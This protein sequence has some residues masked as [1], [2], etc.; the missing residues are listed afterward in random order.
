MP[1]Y[2][3][4]W[5]NVDERLLR[6]I[7]VHLDLDPEDPPAELKA[8]FGARPKEEFVDRSWP[9]L[10]DSWLTSDTR[11]R[12]AVCASLRERGL[13]AAG[14]PDEMAFLRS[15]RNTI[16]LRRVV[17]PEFITLGEG[18]HQVKPVPSSDDNGRKSRLEGFGGRA[19]VGAS[20]SSRP[21]D[22]DDS[23]REERAEGDGDEGL[24]FAPDDEDVPNATDHLRSWV[25]EV[26]SRASGSDIEIDENG[27]VLI[28]HG[29]T[30]VLVGVSDDPLCIEIDAVLLTDVDYSESLYRRLNE[31]NEDILTTSLFHVEED[32]TVYMRNTLI[33]LGLTASHFLGNLAGLAEYANAIDDDLQREFGGRTALESAREKSDAQWV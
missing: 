9:V 31:L 30:M 13:G 17:L 1:R 14:E 2:R 32:R 6:D 27:D 3:F 22:T 28:T 12:R 4:S 20:G 23:R 21:N 19:R 15:C 26:L 16:G 24:L 7:C 29:S 25:H 5:A 33:A 11:A 18:E 8:E 10:R